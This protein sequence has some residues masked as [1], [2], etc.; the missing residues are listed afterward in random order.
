MKNLLSL[1][2]NI[3]NE[4]P[5][6]TSKEE[7]LR[8]N[9]EYWRS[10]WNAYVGKIAKVNTENLLGLSQQEIVSK[11]LHTLPEEYRDLPH[12]YSYLGIAIIARDN[13]F[14]D[15]LW[16]RYW[17]YS[18]RD[19][20]YFDPDTACLTVKRKKPRRKKKLGTRKERLKKY[21]EIK[22]ARN[23]ANRERARQKAEAYSELLTNE[24]RKREEKE[25]KINLQ[26]IISHGFDPE[27]SFR[28]DRQ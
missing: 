1:L 14:T 22:K 28:R 20:Y 10:S 6:R 8:L 21:Y 27:T 7:K 4:R 5:R 18:N 23:K 3:I 11:Y 13:T 16:T 19:V 26:K 24:T 9:K 12:L 15:P 25:K 17:L 2:D